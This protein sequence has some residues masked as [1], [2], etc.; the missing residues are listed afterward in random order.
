MLFGGASHVL[1]PLIPAL[2]AASL[3]R[4]GRTR[5][6]ELEGYRHVLASPQMLC[7]SPAYPANLHLSFC[8][9]LIISIPIC[10]RGNQWCGYGAVVF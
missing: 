2:A 5:Y 4:Y 9:E 10:R 3:E 6:Y 1:L 8:D 7:V